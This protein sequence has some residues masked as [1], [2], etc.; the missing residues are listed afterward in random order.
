MQTFKK[1]WQG[2]NFDESGTRM[3]PDGKSLARSF[4]NL[5]K[6]VRAE[7]G[8]Y[9]VFGFIQRKDGSL[10][11]YNYGDFRGMKIDVNN[12]DCMHGVLLRTA[13]STTDYTGGHNNFSSIAD[14]ETK[15]PQIV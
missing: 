5:M 3:G 4:H 6:V 12:C 14:L 9:Y 8:H 11:Y 10:V 13:T 7:T 1:K 2:F 15:I